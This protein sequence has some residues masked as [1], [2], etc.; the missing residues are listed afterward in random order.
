MDGRTGRL[1]PEAPGQRASSLRM[2]PCLT[3]SPSHVN[4]ARRFGAPETEPGLPGWVGG[5]KMSSCRSPFTCHGPA[6][7][8]RPGTSPWTVV[9]A[10]TL[11]S[12]RVCGRGTWML[13]LVMLADLPTSSQTASERPSPRRPHPHQSCHERA[14]LRWRCG[15]PQRD[16]DFPGSHIGERRL[17]AD[18]SCSYCRRSYPTKSCYA[19][20]N[21]EVI[22]GADQPA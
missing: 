7:A 10:V 4:P 18:D 13:R 21:V 9:L 16:S 2:D 3:F 15:I 22:T 5:P 6:I 8:H 12:T 14:D 1:R 17:E 19:M 20:D 11:V